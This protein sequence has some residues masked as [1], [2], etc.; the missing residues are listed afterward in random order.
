MK[1]VTV[2]IARAWKTGTALVFCSCVVQLCKEKYYLPPL[3]K[4]WFFI[5]HI[6][7]LDGSRVAVPRV[8]L[9]Q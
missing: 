9:W 2:R 4:N 8:L 3:S 7:L 1:W 6:F 5:C